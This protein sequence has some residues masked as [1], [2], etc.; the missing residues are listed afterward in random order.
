MILLLDVGNTRL[1]WARLDGDTLSGQQAVPH[2]N[3]SIADIAT[4]LFASS[5]SIDRILISN[6]AG[7]DLGQ[8]LSD[9]AMRAARVQPEFPRATREF[10]D[11]RNAYSNPGQLGADRWLALLAIRAATKSSAC[12]V[13]IG[14]AMTVDGLASNGQHL[15]GVIVPGPLMMESSLLRETG[16]LAERS[17]TGDIGASLFATN[18]RSA[19]HQ[20]AVQALAALIDR[21][22][23]AV[24]NKTGQPAELFVTGG[25]ADLVIHSLDHQAHVVPDLVLRG[26]AVMVKETAGRQGQPL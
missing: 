6:V 22:L 18:T 2:R 14:T 7:A 11:V 23:A 20:G 19:I 9:A 24:K 3:L 1:K 4:L 21:A 8:Q 26:L 15:G 16:D 13:S 17:A 10:G 5:Q 12:V 25:A